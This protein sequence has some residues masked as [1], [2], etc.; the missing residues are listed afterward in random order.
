MFLIGLSSSGCGFIISNGMVP[1]LSKEIK[2]F[3]NI[4]MVLLC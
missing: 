4:D 3:D 2:Y 1:S